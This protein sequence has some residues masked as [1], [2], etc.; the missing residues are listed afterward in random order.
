MFSEKTLATF[1]KL[2]EPQGAYAQ[3]VA[4]ELP[5]QKIGPTPVKVVEIGSSGTQIYSGYLSEEYLAELR[6]IKAMKLYDMMRRSDPRIKMVVS[7]VKNPIKS[8][9]WVIRHKEGVTDEAMAEKQKLLIEKILFRD[10]KGK[11]SFKKTLHQILSMV[12]FGYSAFEITHRV[13][14]KDPVFGQYIGLKSIKLI[15]Q[16][17]V[18]QFNVNCDGDLESITQY[19]TGDVGRNVIVPS[20]FVMH[21]SID[22]EGDNYEGISML[23]TCYGPWLRKNNALKQESVGNQ[24]FSTPIA[25]MSVP[26]GEQN[27]VQYKNAINFLE[28]YANNTSSYLLKPDGWDLELKSNTFDSSKI[29]ETIKAENEEITFAFLANFLNLGSGGGGGSYALSSEL[30]DF[31]TTSLEF[32]AEEI[33]DAFNTQLIPALVKLNFPNAES[34]IELAV[35]GIADKAGK[36]FAEVM[37]LLVRSRVLTPDDELEDAM[38][39]KFKLPPKADNENIDPVTGEE[40]ESGTGGSGY[41]GEVQK[42]A[43][44][45]PQIASLVSIMTGYSQG[46]Y[47]QESAIAMVSAAFN[48][49]MDKA[50][51]IVGKRMVTAPQN[52]APAPTQLAEKK[53]AKREDPKVIGKRIGDN[54]SHLKNVFKDNL[55]PIG[56]DIINKVM[57]K[58][59]AKPDARAHFSVF[60]IKP[61]GVSAYNELLRKEFGAVVNEAYKSVSTIYNFADKKSIN[62][63]NAKADLLTMTQVN[64]MEKAVYLQFGN[65]VDD[66]DS[67]AAIR[68]DL[69]DA[70][71][72]VLDS[73]ISVGSDIVAAQLENETRMDFFDDIADQIESFTFYNVGP[74]SEICQELNGQT[75][76]INDPELLAV[77]PPLHPNCKSVMIPNMRGDKNNPKIT[78]LPQLS[79]G[80]IKSRT[81]SECFLCNH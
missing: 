13:I 75:F 5:V 37:E 18:Y 61:S 58:W 10:L 36:E 9:D 27:S 20:E 14:L 46:L 21:F 1:K 45:G 26:D 80:A 67:E 78:G 62:R 33:A 41:G 54:G 59:D 81:L 44:S 29:R 47:D 73:Q 2:S 60:D 77:T 4:P 31:F 42:T 71:D 23:R 55:K 19:A 76:A 8:A 43:F 65:S 16:K 39:K 34:L 15:G 12:E 51:T 32:I 72:K 38:R 22:Q 35:S 57:A 24:N 3:T 30:S 64:D 11:K 68:K 49:S 40:I 6:G 28:N 7:A 70:L 17:T 69:E 66:T 48:I 63:A 56:M 52:A 79:A 25:V 50:T 74:I 53:T